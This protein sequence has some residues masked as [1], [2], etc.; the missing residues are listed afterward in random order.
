M[1]KKKM[2]KDKVATYSG[3]ELEGRVDE[4]IVTLQNLISAHGPTVS[5]GYEQCKWEDDYEFNVYLER[6]ETAVERSR[7]LEKQKEDKAKREKWDR[8]HYEE[9]KKKFGD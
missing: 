1:A 3:F 8:R 7:R 9:L 4:V 6:E 2:V 5:I